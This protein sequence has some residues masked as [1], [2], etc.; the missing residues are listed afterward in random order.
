MV[1]FIPTSKKLWILSFVI[2]SL[3]SAKVWDK[4]CQKKQKKKLGGKKFDKNK[5]KL[6]IKSVIMLGVK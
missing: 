5:I 6:G 4:I 2:Y 1:H 3:I